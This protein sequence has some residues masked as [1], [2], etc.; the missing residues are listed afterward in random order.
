M[1][2]FVKKQ[3][4]RPMTIGAQGLHELG[5]A[6][7]QSRQVI[8]APFGRFDMHVMTRGAADIA[9]A[10]LVSVVVKDGHFAGRI[11]ENRAPDLLRPGDDLWRVL[12]RV[13]RIVVAT[14]AKLIER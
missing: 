7:V 8:R 10:R 6:Q 5:H 9:D 13:G 2:E 12:G 4:L 1:E 11:A 14:A 3:R